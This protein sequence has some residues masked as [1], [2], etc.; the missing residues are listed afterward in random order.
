MRGRSPEDRARRARLHGIETR[1]AYFGELRSALEDLSCPAELVRPGPGALVLRVR[2]C[3]R[4][5]DSVDIRCVWVAGEWWFT[6]AG[7]DT[8]GPAEDHDGAALAIFR[9][10]RQGPVPS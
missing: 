2:Y 8:I 10:L 6:W 9:V 7:G 5:P 4:L 1:E 3:G